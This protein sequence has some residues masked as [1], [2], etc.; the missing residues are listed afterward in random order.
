VRRC[1]VGVGFLHPAPLYDFRRGK[2]KNPCNKCSGVGYVGFMKNLYARGEAGKEYVPKSSDFPRA[3]KKG[4][5]L[6]PYDVKERNE[7]R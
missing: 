5:T 1:R 2:A 7:P 4:A 3:R 6:H